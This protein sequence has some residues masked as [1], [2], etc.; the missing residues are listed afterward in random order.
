MARAPRARLEATE[1]RP[2]S[3]VIPG[4]TA[5]RMTSTEAVAA[6]TRGSARLRRALRLP[7]GNGPILIDGESVKVVGIAGVVRLAPSIELDIA[8]K[9]HGF[10]HPGWREDLLAISNYTRRGSFI[11]QNVRAGI[12]EAGDLASVI[13]RAFVGEFW[14]HYRKPLRL[15]RERR[16]RGFELEGE[17]DA[18]LPYERSA[19][20]FP[21]QA[22]VLDRRN[23]YN[24]VIAAAAEALVADVRDAALRTQLLRVRSY[25]GDQAPA[26]ATM[27]RPVPARHRPWADLVELSRAIASGADLTLHADRFEA[28]GYVIRTW[29]AWEQLVFRALRSQLGL[30]RARHHLPYSW[31]ERE[32]K[33]LEVRPDVTVLGSGLPRLVDAKYRTH[34]EAGRRRIHRDDLME[35]AAFMA[36]AETDLIALLYP[37]PGDAQILPCGGA[38]VFDVVT[39]SPGRRV[40]AVDAEVRGF[41]AR[42]AHRQFAA[43][44]AAAVERV[45]G[46]PE[47]EPGDSLN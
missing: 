17:L 40:V 31:G 47:V 37:R 33:A 27:L 18:D 5:A 42:N 25:L 30:E 6:L 19:D 22:M 28:P 46:G 44:V 15:Y 20:G 26:E 29:E 13:G 35:A 10:S 21:Q 14:K 32:G 16:W 3:D 12:D 23:P 7:E 34:A 1:Q 43:G 8:P 2:S 24:A 36:A 39:L 38:K 45:F 41:S 11:A 4:L 9:F